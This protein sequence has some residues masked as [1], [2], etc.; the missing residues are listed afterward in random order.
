M[1]SFSSATAG[2]SLLAIFMVLQLS[3]VAMAADHIVGGDKGWT[4]NFNYSEW[5]KDQVF[6]VGDNLVFNYNNTKHNVFQ[7]NGTM[8]QSCTIPD[9]SNSNQSLSS[10]HDVIRLD[11]EGKKWYI[12]GFSN[13]CRDL[14]MKL[15]VNVTPSAASSLLSSASLLLLVAAMLA[16]ATISI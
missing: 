12:C 3:S 4:T 8:F 7:V 11:T 5:A 13:H 16:T 9:S 6:V 14:G 2:V 1:A 10:G 15:S